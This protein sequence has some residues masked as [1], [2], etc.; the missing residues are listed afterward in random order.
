LSTPPCWV[1]SAW[2]TDAG[3]ANSSATTI[4]PSG[5]PEVCCSARRDVPLGR[6]QPAVDEQRAERLL[7]RPEATLSASADTIATE[8][9][10]SYFRMWGPSPQLPLS[11]LGIG[12][13]TGD[14]R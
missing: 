4:A 14:C 3:V 7:G 13:K 10:L 5:F 12:Q 6:D 8:S 2:A 1:A 11:K 9:T